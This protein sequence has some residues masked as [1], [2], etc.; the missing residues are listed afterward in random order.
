MIAAGVMHS[1]EELA[2]SSKFNVYLVGTEL[3]LVVNNPGKLTA[4]CCF[5]SVILLINCIAPALHLLLNVIYSV[6]VFEILNKFYHFSVLF[7][8]CSVKC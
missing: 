6:V 7:E 4:F 5:Y 3:S 1:S 8:F 2:S